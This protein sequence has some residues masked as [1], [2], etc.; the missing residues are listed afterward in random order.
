MAL[1]LYP[2]AWR[3]RYAREFAALLEDV[4][5][6]W[7][8]CWDV[9]RGGLKMRMLTW[10]LASVTVVCALLGA[11]AGGG[12]ALRLP[13]Q[14]IST[15]VLRMAGDAK[16][17]D[18]VRTQS[19]V[20]SPRSLR[21]IILK[22]GLY[23]EE[24]QRTPMEA[25]VS[26]VRNKHIR[27]VPLA[28]GAGGSVSAFA[29]S[30]QYPDGAKAQTMTRVLSAQFVQSLPSIRVLDP[31]TLPGRPATPNRLAFTLIGLILGIGAGILAV[32]V[33]RWPIV[34]ASGAAAAVAALAIAYAIPDRWVSSA[35][36]SIDPATPGLVQAVL[37][38]AVLQKIIEKDSMQLYK[39]E[40]TKAPMSEVIRRMRE[41]DLEI[42]EV[43]FIGKP[44]IAVKFA[45]VDRFKA[46][47]A[48]REVVSTLTE[49]NY[50][51]A[52]K[53]APRFQEL[54]VVAPA[55]FPASPSSPNRL[56]IL[57]AG[58]TAGLMAGVVVTRKRRLRAAGAAA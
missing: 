24:R 52:S 11:A 14:Y 10:N 32:G 16:V 26:E 54:S 45:Y 55:S 30:F 3:E 34:A 6:G 28:G 49:V 15:A 2:K 37:D 46:Q 51:E 5:A 36:L 39:K 35:V 9:A 1:W 21:E 18:L 31:A 48:V 25:L 8:D 38:D 20:L 47:A 50:V 42:R 23:P 17:E 27:I 41:R 12:W 29:I 44:A 19:G 53:G 22:E 57:I 40:R 33:R 13:D 58:L 4:G 7:R 56:V 43:F